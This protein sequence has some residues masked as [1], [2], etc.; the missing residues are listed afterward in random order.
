MFYNDGKTEF[1]R[2]IRNR[3]DARQ[4]VFE[5]K[6]VKTLRPENVNQLYRY[7]DEEF[8]R[9]GVLATRHPPPRA[10]LRNTVD[11]HSS[12]RFVI[13]CLDDS[14]LE[15]MINL[16]ESGRHPIEALKKKFV[17]FTRLLPK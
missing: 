15:L 16:L 10:I 7:L 8:G 9:F 11:L 14:D 2:D 13:L 12:K 4:I 1:L 5:L 3:Y 6:N 17:E